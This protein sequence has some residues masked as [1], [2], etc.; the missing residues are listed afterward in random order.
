MKLTMVYPLPFHIQEAIDAYNHFHAFVDVAKATIGGRAL[1]IDLHAQIHPTNW[2]ELGYTI[3]A[4]KLN[5]GDF[6]ASDSTIKH[7]GGLTCTN[8]RCA[9]VNACVRAC[10]R[11]CKPFACTRTFV[12]SVGDVIEKQSCISTNISDPTNLFE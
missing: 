1:V 9:C 3:P 7:L 2:T 10:M 12:I 5:S 11:A 8:G 6:T 4:S